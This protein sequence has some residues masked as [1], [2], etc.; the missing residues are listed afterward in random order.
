MGSSAWTLAFYQG[1]GRPIWRTSRDC[2]ITTKSDG[3]NIGGGGLW[4]SLHQA[5]SSDWHCFLLVKASLD[6]WGLSI[7]NQHQYF[8][9]FTFG[10]LSMSYW[11]IPIRE[12][13]KRVLS[14]SRQWASFSSQPHLRWLCWLSLG[15]QM[16]AQL[17]PVSHVVSLHHL[18]IGPATI[19]CSWEGT[20]FYQKYLPGTW[21]RTGAPLKPCL[22]F[23]FPKERIL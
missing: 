23:L 6:L 11:S 12:E 2:S 21:I 22:S 5:N 4:K 15:T 3:Q 9:Q 7:N 18:I 20:S 14:I 16:F 19:P 17:C 8:P 13:R 10:W 1:L